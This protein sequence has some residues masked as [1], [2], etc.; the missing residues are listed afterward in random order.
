MSHTQC[1]YRAVFKRQQNSSLVHFVLL[2]Q[3]WILCIS[4]YCGFSTNCP[5]LCQEKRKSA[6]FRSVDFTPCEWF[7]ESN[8]PPMFLVKK[9]TVWFLCE[10]DRTKISDDYFKIMILGKCQRKRSLKGLRTI[11]CQYE[12]ALL[13]QVICYIGSDSVATS[14]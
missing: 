7:P 4:E 6:T 3:E 11:C 8:T 2:H 14:V 9:E 12:N 13:I 1:Y 5:S 10:C